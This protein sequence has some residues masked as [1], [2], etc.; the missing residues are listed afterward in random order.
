MINS[1]S[2][3]VVQNHLQI[4]W[5]YCREGVQVVES[6]GKLIGLKVDLLESQLG[7]LKSDVRVAVG[8]TRS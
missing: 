3:G 8:F 1:L 7:Q 2:V 6:M 4:E 5:L